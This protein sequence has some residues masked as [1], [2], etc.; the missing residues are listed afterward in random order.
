MLQR[1]SAGRVGDSI[2]PALLGLVA[3]LGFA[4]WGWIGLTLLSILG[5]I[6][7]GRGMSARR[8]AWRGYVF[9]L[10]HFSSGLYWVYI[11]IYQYGG[12]P[13]WL[14]WLL[15]FVLASYLALFPALLG[16]VWRRWFTAGVVQEA[17]VIL[18]LLWLLMELLR[19][20]LFTGL[21]WLALGYA[22]IDTPLARLAPVTGVYGM[23]AALVLLAGA[24]WLLATGDQRARGIAVSVMSLL[25]IAL[26]L[27]PPPADWTRASGP[28]IEVSLVQG[29]IPQEFK[30]RPGRREATQA[31]YRE[32]T[33]SEWGRRLIIWPEVA[34]PALRH[35]VEAYLDE[36]NA[37]AQDHG[38]TLLVGVLVRDEPKGPLYNA[39][40]SLGVDQGS[41]YKRHLLPFGE[42]FP[43]PK[44]LLD[45]GS[46]LGLQYSDF[47]SG[48]DDQP[49]LMLGEHYLGMSIC[50][51][52]VFG[53]DIRRDLP[54]AGLL[55]NVT[56]DAWFDDSSAPH[57][58]LQIARMRALEMGRTLL[59]VANTGI[60]AVIGPDGTLRASSPQFE[61][62]VLRASV[63]P[64]SGATP[65]AAVGDLPLWILGFAGLGF[66]FFRLR[67]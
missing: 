39:L 33:E 62:D 40:L 26:W 66:A 32:L 1:L 30:W 46:I 7:L 35:Q 49:P 29:N 63:T 51:E 24:A 65:Y 37:M 34:I 67:P 59:R 5:V 23:S 58:H 64:R 13:L 14:S 21:P 44:F 42:Y 47:S 8:A 38:S 10:A 22:F 55:V 17:L 12:G 27:L 36:L 31:H 52:D 9:G 50:F 54:R 41:Y 11:S 43:A 20:W 56:N 16:Y 45:I 3:T 19:G 57:Q 53:R 48:S 18:P 15:V 61:V 2:W 60:S 25:A 6:W 28:P 4:P